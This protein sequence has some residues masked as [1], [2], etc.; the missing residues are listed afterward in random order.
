MN[1][2]DSEQKNTGKNAC[3]TNAR[4]KAGIAALKGRS[5]VVLHEQCGHFH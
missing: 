3:A 1:A 2:G 4:M 5:T